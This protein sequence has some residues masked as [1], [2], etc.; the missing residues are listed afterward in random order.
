MIISMYSPYGKI[1]WET[2]NRDPEGYEMT[3]WDELPDDIVRNYNKM[4][5]AVIKQ[6]ERNRNDVY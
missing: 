2:D 3:P 5:E 1:L 4:A 6:Y